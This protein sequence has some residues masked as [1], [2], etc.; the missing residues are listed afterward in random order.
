MLPVSTLIG[1]WPITAY[2]QNKFIQLS[3]R[4]RGTGRFYISAHSCKNGQLKTETGNKE[5]LKKQR[6]AN[7]EPAITLQ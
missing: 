1:I 5:Q 4:Y 2:L 7:S 6:P 3:V